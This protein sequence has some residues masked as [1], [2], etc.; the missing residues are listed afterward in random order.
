MRPYPYH[1]IE[2]FSFIFSDCKKNYSAFSI[3]LSFIY[4][5]AKEERTVK[6]EDRVLRH[7]R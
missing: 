5:I 7:L 4:T 6:S 1:D 3:R 2:Q